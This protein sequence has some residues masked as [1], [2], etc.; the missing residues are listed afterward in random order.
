MADRRSLGFIGWIYGG[1]TA[2]V[3]VTAMLVVQRHLDGRMMLDDGPHAV[4]S[5]SLPTL[6]R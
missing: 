2:L 1:I 6:V 3:M 4:I 5:A